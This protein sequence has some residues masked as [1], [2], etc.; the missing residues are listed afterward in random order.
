[1]AVEYMIF[2]WNF[3][4]FARIRLEM[5]FYNRYGWIFLRIR[6]AEKRF[7][8]NGP[9]KINKIFKIPFLRG[10]FLRRPF[11]Q[12]PFFWGSFFTGTIF[13]GTIFPVTV[14]LGILFPRDHF[15]G[16]FLSRDFFSRGPFC[17]D[18]FSE[19]F[20]S[21]IPRILIQIINKMFYLCTMSLESLHNYF[22]ITVKSWKKDEKFGFFEFW[23]WSRNKVEMIATLR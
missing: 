9:H 19:D 3:N 17:G 18:H 23:L 13:P 21:G 16:D 2:S 14:F 4:N 5:C 1:M 12:G 10:P 8:K 20:F 7:P 11:F 22:G 6:Y 15:S